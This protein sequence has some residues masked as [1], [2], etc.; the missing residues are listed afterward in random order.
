MSYVYYSYEEWGRG[1]IGSRARSPEG[2]ECYFG[3]YTDKAF[4]PTEK[5]ILARFKTAREAIEAECALHTFYDVARNPHFANKAKQTSSGFTTAGVKMSEE[6]KKKISA[7]NTGKVKSAETR[8]KMSE[9]NYSRTEK[10]KE[11]KRGDKN[12]MRRQEVRSKLKGNKSRTGVKNSKEMNSKIGK[13]LN[14]SKW[15]NNGTQSKRIPITEEKPEGW[16]WGRHF[17]RRSSG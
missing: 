2:D 15:I 14:K 5:I 10:A 17:S 8:K 12:P 7:G 1:Y 13:W 4:A 16:K 11:S 6:M 9:N 3:S